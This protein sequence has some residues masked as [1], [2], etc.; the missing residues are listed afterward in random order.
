MEIVVLGQSKIVFSRRGGGFQCWLYDVQF[1]QVGVQ[2]SVF[3][4]ATSCC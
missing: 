4:L 3:S 1:T 2:T